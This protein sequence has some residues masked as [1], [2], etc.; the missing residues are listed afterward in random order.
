[1]IAT[2]PPTFVRARPATLDQILND[3]P[4]GQCKG[5]GAVCALSSQERPPAPLL[6]PTC[7]RAAGG[8][9]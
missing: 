9:R 7:L 4:L 8:R 3:R 5:C 1:M 6:C 2:Q